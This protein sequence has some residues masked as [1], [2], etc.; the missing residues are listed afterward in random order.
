MKRFFLKAGILSFA[1]ILTVVII[2]L[3]LLPALRDPNDYL[4]ASA[5]KEKRENSISRPKIILVGGSNLA[6]GINS[7][8]IEKEFKMPVVNMGLHAGLG[9]EF[10]LNEAIGG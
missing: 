6:F 8:I 3:F 4:G 9:L 7:E 1:I 2:I 10:T 5:E